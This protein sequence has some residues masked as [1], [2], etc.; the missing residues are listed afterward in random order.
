MHIAGVPLFSKYGMALIDREFELICLPIRTD[1][2]MMFVIRIM[3]KPWDRKST[4][5]GMR[6]QSVVARNNIRKGD[7]K[8]QQIE[9]F[10]CSY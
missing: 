9:S 10:G 6:W 2:D 8:P 4:L 3:H 1:G 7:I 5:A